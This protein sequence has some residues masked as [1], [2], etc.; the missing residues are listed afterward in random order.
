MPALSSVL[1]DGKALVLVAW[2]LPSLPT[3][4]GLG[5]DLLKAS[6]FHSAP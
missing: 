5:L 2:I 3:Y 6:T 1:E 4:I